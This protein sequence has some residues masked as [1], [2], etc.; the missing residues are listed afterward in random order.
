MILHSTRTELERYR[1]VLLFMSFISELVTMMTSSAEGQMSLMH[2][3]TILRR[4]VSLFWNSLVTEKN[5]SD[6]S[7]CE[8]RRG[9]V[10][11]GGGAHAHKQMYMGESSPCGCGAGQSIARDLPTKCKR[12]GS[13]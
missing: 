12:K 3:Y 4:L 7:F 10:M 11:N 13:F 8:V 9:R 5:T 6:A 1:S 2:R